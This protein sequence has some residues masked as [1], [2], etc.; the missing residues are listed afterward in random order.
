MT[1]PEMMASALASCIGCYIV[2]YCE[3]ANIDASGM[4]V[5]CDWVVSEKPKRIESFGVQV[6]LPH[7]LEKRRKAMMRVA[8]S[9]L[10]HATLERPPEVHNRYHKP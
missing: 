6:D 1:P 2:R 7:L 3:Q 5:S 8:Q 9:C 4:V 10:I